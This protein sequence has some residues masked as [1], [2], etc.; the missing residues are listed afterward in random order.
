MN[1]ERERETEVEDRYTQRD[2]QTNHSHTTHTQ[3]GTHTHIH[4][5]SYTH[6]QQGIP[7]HT[8]NSQ[9]QLEG[10]VEKTAAEIEEAARSGSDLRVRVTA[11]HLRRQRVGVVKSMLQ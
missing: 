6:T 8:H 11:A 5:L 10:A 1:R 2:T 7:G 3:T 4:S 9:G